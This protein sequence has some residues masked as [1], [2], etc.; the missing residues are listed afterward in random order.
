MSSLR[1]VVME[2]ASLQGRSPKTPEP[3]N[4]ESTSSDAT[5]R[6]SRKRGM[7]GGDLTLDD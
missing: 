6:R 2:R 3:E 5:P 4:P 7:F 1:W